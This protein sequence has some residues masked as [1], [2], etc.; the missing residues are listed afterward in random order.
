MF[1]RRNRLAK[2]KDVSRTYARG[3]AFFTPHFTIKFLASS[4]GEPSRFTVVVST[5]VAKQAVKRNKIK[6]VV[7]ECI[8]R[9]MAELKKGD[10]MIL[11]KP[12][13]VRFTPAVLSDTIQAALVQNK[14]LV[15]ASK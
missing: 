15:P 7:R 11:V 6:R 14:L 13:A 1:A 12:A 3:R 8:R 4:P 10:Y 9:H 2:D 5:K